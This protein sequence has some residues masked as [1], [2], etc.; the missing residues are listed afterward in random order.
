L[1]NQ[2]VTCFLSSP[3]DSASAAF[4]ASCTTHTRYVHHAGRL[5]QCMEYY[6]LPS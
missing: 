4:S 6:H 5:D 2:L 1:M 3:V